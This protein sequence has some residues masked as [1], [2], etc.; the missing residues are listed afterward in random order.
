MP[1]LSFLVSCFIFCLL[2]TYAQAEDKADIVIIKE[3]PKV[4][5]E[6]SSEHNRMGKNLQ[7]TLIAVG[8]GPVAGPV[9]GVNLSYII[10]RNSLVN[11][12]YV[13][14]AQS[15]YTC[16]GSIACAATG[17]AVT[18]SYKSFVSN[19]FY[20]TVGI[21]RREAGYNE[22]EVPSGTTSY[23]FTGSSIGAEIS[24]GNQW[25]WKNFTLGCDWIGYNF[26]LSH[27]IDSEESSGDIWDVTNLDSREKTFLANNTPLALRF[28]LGASF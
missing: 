11:L 16:S 28:Y 17:N 3:A 5:Y 7:A 10:D 2:S 13:K 9:T 14:L 18:L 23:T 21:G 22:A 1:K 8:F 6:N 27:K 24:I 19:S 15:A 26:P 25:Q 20:Y 4:I 12:S